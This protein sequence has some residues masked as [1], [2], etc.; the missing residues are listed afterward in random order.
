MNPA[1]IQSKSIKYLFRSYRGI[2]CN[3]LRN[4]HSV[5]V[6]KLFKDEP[7]YG[8]GTVMPDSPRLSP[9]RFIMK[10]VNIG[11]YS[12]IYDQR[13]DQEEFSAGCRYVFF[14][15]SDILRR[16]AIDEL[17]SLIPDN[18]SAKLRSAITRLTDSERTYLLDFEEKNLINDRVYK[19]DF[20]KDP[21]NGA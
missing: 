6:I 10:Y 12:A 16:K 4:N 11:R 2:N 17:E 1:G 3:S 19:C 13:F 15:L 21:S 8:A 9:L 14:K 20:Q 7:V 5:N 18:F